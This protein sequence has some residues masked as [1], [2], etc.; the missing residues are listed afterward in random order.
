LFC[1]VSFRILKNSIQRW[2]FFAEFVC[3]RRPLEMRFA[4]ASLM[5]NELS[6]AGTARGMPVGRLLDW[7]PLIDC[8]LFGGG[9]R[10]SHHNSASLARSLSSSL[11]ERGCQFG[12]ADSRLRAERRRTET[13]Q[14]T[15]RRRLMRN[16]LVLISI[17]KWVG[18]AEQR[19]RRLWHN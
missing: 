5:L 18:R 19:A 1:F 8:R 6:R 13:T 17:G 11:V 7:R 15:H 9:L 12:P 2:P 14:L 3:F 10:E 4:C 16:T